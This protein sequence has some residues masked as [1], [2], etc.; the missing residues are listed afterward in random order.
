MFGISVRANDLKV[1]QSCRGS[2]RSYPGASAGSPGAASFSAAS[3]ASDASTPSSTTSSSVPRIAIRPNTVARPAS[4]KTTGI[5]NSAAMAS[6]TT[7]SPMSATQPH[8]MTSKVWVVPPRPKPGRKPATDT[9]PTKRKAQNRAAQRAFRERRAAR[10]GELEEQLE[11]QKEE[12]EKAVRELQER[13]HHLE[14]EAQSLRS[15]CQWLEKSFEEERQRGDALARNWENSQ[16]ARSNSI[17]PT[18][19]FSPPPP[20]MVSQSQSS[21]LPAPRQDAADLNVRAEP[22]PPAQSI[23]IS[24]IISP[25][26]EETDILEFSCGNCQ[27]NGSCSCAEEAL[28]ETLQMSSFGCGGCTPDTRCACLEESIQASIAADLKRPFPPS[29][30][31]REPE[32]KRQRS[33][34]VAT[35]METD[36]TALF[37]ST[38]NDT[39]PVMVSQPTPQAQPLASLEPRD[40][41]GFCKDGTYC[42][43]ADSASSIPAA[44]PPATAH[45]IQTP[46]PSEDDVIP[47]PMEVTATGAIKLPGVRAMRQGRPAAAAAAAAVTQPVRSAGGCGP[48]GP[49]TC[50]QCLADPK[51]GLFCRSLAANMQRKQEADVLSSSAGGC[52]RNGGPGGCCKTGNAGQENATAQATTSAASK[53]GAGTAGSSFSVSLPCAEAY[54]T[55]ASHRNFNEAADDIGSWLPKLR[56]APIPDHIKNGRGVP[57]HIPCRWAPIEVEAA[58]IM[59]VLKDF[60]VRFGRGE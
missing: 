24:Q 30:P 48:N 12:H 47:A 9:P 34:T 46:P 29:S 56:A 28:Q 41:C 49:G 6:A 23:S 26:E 20:S 3:P 10:V 54:Q 4:I 42:F 55:L 11:E 5:T 13:I 1:V 14:N 16:A 17:L 40:A 2:P 33:D 38:S 57:G 44:A 43:C 15:R 27:A 45:Q 50:A 31:G 36:F 53:A 59:T 60:D 22:R 21:I 52:C 35:S 39:G 58:S 25:P 32:G 37:A 51:S 8:S 19:V 18:D 7:P